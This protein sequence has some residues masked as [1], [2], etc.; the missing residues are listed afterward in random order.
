MDPQSPPKI[1]PATSLTK[2]EHE[3]SRLWRN[4]LFFV[5]LLAVGLGAASW[6]NLSQVSERYG[7]L[8]LAAVGLT[9]AFA[10]YTGK[11]RSE[12]AHLRS[13]LQAIQIASIKPGN[14]EHLSNL[15]EVIGR[16]Q[17]GFRELVDALEDVVLALSMD[18]VIQA[19]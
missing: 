18:G 8:P 7:V 16:S 1:D 12:I 2:L 14:E 3:E 11:K 10:F 6:Q 13:E 9:I 5:A 19:A 4:A 15:V 17:R